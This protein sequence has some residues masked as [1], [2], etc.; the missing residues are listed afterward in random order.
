M[1]CHEQ[2]SVSAF[3][4]DQ[5]WRIVFNLAIHHPFIFLALLPL[6]NLKNLR[7]Q[8][9]N[10]IGKQIPLILISKILQAIHLTASNVYMYL[11][12]INFLK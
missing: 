3:F 6:L 11:F 4:I 8:Y 1:L 10:L 12:G 5:I 2:N 9:Q 7:C